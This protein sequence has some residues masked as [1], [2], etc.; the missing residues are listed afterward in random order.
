VKK[1]ITSHRCKPTPPRTGHDARVGDF[2][3]GIV[4]RAIEVR[5]INER[6]SMDLAI[7]LNPRRTLK[8]LL[9]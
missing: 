7:G 3:D 9:G 6:T 1:T 5:R 8:A 4:A 2:P